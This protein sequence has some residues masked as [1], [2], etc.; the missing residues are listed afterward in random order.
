MI[1]FPPGIED[2]TSWGNTFVEFGK[3]AGK[4]LVYEDLATSTEKEHK[5]DVKWRIGQVDASEGRL[6]DLS[7]CFVARENVA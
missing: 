6:R 7:L 5:S 4:E 2:L 1:S 3:H